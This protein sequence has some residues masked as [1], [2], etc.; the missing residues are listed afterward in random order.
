MGKETYIADCCGATVGRDQ[1]GVMF[2]SGGITH[3]SE[4]LCLGYWKQRA[5]AAEASE[6][7]YQIA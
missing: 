4:I 1:D 2:C 7:D 3:F 5:E 6:Q